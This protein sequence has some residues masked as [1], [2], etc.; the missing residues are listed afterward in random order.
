MLD[1]AAEKEIIDEYKTELRNAN[2]HE[3]SYE[4]QMDYLITDQMGSDKFDGI[5]NLAIAN[6]DMMCAIS[7]HD[8]VITYQAEI[9][10]LNLNGS[11]NRF[12]S[13]EVSIKTEIYKIMTVISQF[14]QVHRSFIEFALNDVKKLSKMIV[15]PNTSWTNVYI[16]RRMELIE[17]FLERLTPCFDLIRECDAMLEVALSALKRMKVIFLELEDVNA[18][19]DFLNK[20]KKLLDN[21]GYHASSRRYKHQIKILSD[22]TV[23]EPKREL[24]IY[25]KRQKFNEIKDAVSFEE[26]ANHWK[27]N[28]N[29]VELRE[30]LSR[31]ISSK[32]IN[33]PKERKRKIDNLLVS[34]SLIGTFYTLRTLLKKLS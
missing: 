33:E 13:P 2:L 16:L 24:N 25:H 26:I 1:A 27:N 9:E 21:E 11:L 29:V 23:K 20:F 19:D 6:D 10:R 14:N 34:D 7:K 18:S 3:I 8:E 17:I 12:E 31:S 5:K 4:L 32:I 28:A 22:E 15:D 30:L